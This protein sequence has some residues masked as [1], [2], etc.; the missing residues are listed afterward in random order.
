MA[1]NPIVESPKFGENPLRTDNINSFVHKIY[2]K[3]NI[4]PLNINSVLAISKQ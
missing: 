2:V 4:K 1:R 3:I